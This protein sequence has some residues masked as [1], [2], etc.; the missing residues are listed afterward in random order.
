ML[1]RIHCT[2]AHPIYPQHPTPD[3]VGTPNTKAH[4]RTPAADPLRL[5]INDTT[6]PQGSLVSREG[7]PVEGIPPTAGGTTHPDQP[8]S[9]LGPGGPDQATDSLDRTR[10]HPASAITL[11]AGSY[12]SPR[13][14][15]CTYIPPIMRCYS[16]L[17]CQ[18]F[19]KTFATTFLNNFGAFTAHPE[20]LPCLPIGM[21]NPAPPR[22]GMPSAPDTWGTPHITAQ[23]TEAA[24][25]GLLT[26]D[27]STHHGP[28][29]SREDTSFGNIPHLAV[30]AK[31]L[32]QPRNPPWPGRPS[33]GADRLCTSNSASS[34]PLPLARVCPP[35][36][37]QGAPPA[38]VPV[39]CHTSH[40]QGSYHPSIFG[41][42]LPTPTRAHGTTNEAPSPDPR[43]IPPV[44]SI[45]DWAHL[46]LTHTH[47]E[48]DALATR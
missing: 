47:E 11:Q 29:T 1:P 24:P 20:S 8:R 34:G 3:V 12:N 45:E 39:G 4:G 15:H 48:F 27:G 26:T 31:H 44:T 38:P 36:H 18:R 5:R 46:L 23:R 25:Q 16:A 43:Q 40:P 6:N 17:I 35:R 22:H 32:G 13:A 19:Y 2:T 42:G 9:L 30:G 28:L 33:H 10:S 7:T 41:G 37:T 21:H 14:L